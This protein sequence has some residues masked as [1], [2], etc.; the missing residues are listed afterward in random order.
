ME[1]TSLKTQITKLAHTLQSQEQYIKYLYGVIEGHESEIE[2]LRQ[3]N[4][5]L[6]KIKI[7][8]RIDLKLLLDDSHNREEYL[9]QELNNTRASTTEN[10]STYEDAYANEVRHH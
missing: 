7:I 9:K 1:E 5:E 8:W 2:E 6:R 10:K 4:A 3:K